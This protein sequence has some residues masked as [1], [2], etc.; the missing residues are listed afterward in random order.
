MLS[1]RVCVSVCIRSLSLGNLGEKQEI[2]RE[3]IEICG[4][5]TEKIYR[6]KDSDD[7]RE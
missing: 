3:D 2:W 7:V 4:K 6:V 1:S 5:K